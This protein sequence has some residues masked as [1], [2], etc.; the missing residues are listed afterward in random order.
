MNKEE[1]KTAGLPFAL[2]IISVILLCVYLL[3]AYVFHN[4]LNIILIIFPLTSI[5]G[6]IDSLI[7]RKYVKR[8]KGIRTAGFLCCLLC[9]LGF[10]S[11]EVLSLYYMGL[12]LG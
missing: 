12:A 6:L 2:G 9:I 3:D 11:I 8:H 1:I 4:S 10:I 7:I 5:V